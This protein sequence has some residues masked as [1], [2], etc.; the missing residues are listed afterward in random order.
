MVWAVSC[1]QYIFMRP[2]E[3]KYLSGGR[4]SSS[5]SAGTEHESFYSRYKSKIVDGIPGPDKML[6]ARICRKAGDSED[7]PPYA[8]TIV[9]QKQQLSIIHEY[10]GQGQHEKV[11]RVPETYS[12]D[13]HENPANTNLT[14]KDLIRAACFKEIP[15]I[16]V[17]KQAQN[18]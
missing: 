4:S 18:P 9:D 1:N 6:L 11:C 14:C 10:P 16:L 8:G 15:L 2:E 3:H 5:V 7:H 13:S 17:P 12:K